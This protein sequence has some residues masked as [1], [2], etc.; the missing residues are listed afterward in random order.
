MVM[1]VS[2][3]EDGEQPVAIGVRA[4]RS[5]GKYQY[6]R[7]YRAKFAVPKTPLSTKADEIELDPATHHGLCQH[8]DI[9]PN[10]SATVVL[11]DSTQN[12]TP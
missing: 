3:S 1:S 5:G 11:K 12:D 2:P 6:F 10:G 8:I 7:L 9:A 4:A